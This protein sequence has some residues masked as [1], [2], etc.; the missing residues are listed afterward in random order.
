MCASQSHPLNYSPQYTRNTRARG[1]PPPHAPAALWPSTRTPW[2]NGPQAPTCASS[3]TW[4]L[5]TSTSSVRDSQDIA[6]HCAQPLYDANHRVCAFV[7]HWNAECLTG[8]CVPQY[9]RINAAI[10]AGPFCVLSAK[11]VTTSRCT[12]DACHAL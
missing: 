12:F 10:A 7:S 9:E 2:L 3:C 4:V 5:S 6:E 1:T 11:P 8:S